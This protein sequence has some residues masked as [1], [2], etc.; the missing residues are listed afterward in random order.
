MLRSIFKISNRRV[1]TTTSRRHD[2]GVNLQWYSSS[3]RRKD[4]FRDVHERA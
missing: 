2:L 3:C 1:K 4:G